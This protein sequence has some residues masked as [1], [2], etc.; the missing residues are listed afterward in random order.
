MFNMF[1]VVESLKI[2]GA[3]PH[4]PFISRFLENGKVGNGSDMFGIVRIY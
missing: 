3:M 2:L 4:G 1:K